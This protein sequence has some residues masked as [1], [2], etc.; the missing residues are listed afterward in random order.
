MNSRRSWFCLLV[1]QQWSHFWPFFFFHL[2]FFFFFFPLPSLCP[3]TVTANILKY[4]P[5]AKYTTKPWKCSR[6]QESLPSLKLQGFTSLLQNKSPK[7][8]WLNMI[9]INYYEAV[10]RLL[11]FSASVGPCWSGMA[12]LMFQWL[13][14]AAGLDYGGNWPWISHL[15][16]SWW[17][18]FPLWQEGISVA[19][20]KSSMCKLFSNFCLCPIYE[21]RQYIKN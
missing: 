16:A 7:T 15:P 19:R 9:V 6:A 21:P 13:V 14:L 8:L 2:C 5:N 17:G 11:D 20:E 10:S 18:F 12:S 3:S 1:L 4:L